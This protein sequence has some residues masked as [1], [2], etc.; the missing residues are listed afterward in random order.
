M[1]R[2]QAVQTRR[3]L[4]NSAHARRSA[5][6]RLLSGVGLLLIGFAMIA[7]L[8]FPLLAPAPE[9][10]P[11]ELVLDIDSNEAVLQEVYIELDEQR[12]TQQLFGWHERQPN[13]RVFAVTRPDQGV[14][15]QDQPRMAL[16]VGHPWATQDSVGDLTAGAPLCLTVA[17]TVVA[18]G[19]EWNVR[20]ASAPITRRY[21]ADGTWS[22][23][24]T[25]TVGLSPALRALAHDD[26]FGLEPTLELSPFPH[27]WL[28]DTQGF[29]TFVGCEGCETKAVF[30]D[31]E[32]VESD[33]AFGQV[34]LTERLGVEIVSPWQPFASVS[35]GS[36]GGVLLLAFGSAAVVGALGFLWR[37]RHD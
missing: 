21:L 20:L 27:D 37:T 29:I 32:L 34:R 8:V 25:V 26:A 35:P 33:L 19:W 28:G 12:D 1:S 24:W 9:P 18:T 3:S 2:R 14:N 5:I 13:L 31:A 15:C 4:R 16:E 7:L 23:S 10:R 11:I 6:R 22:E 36:V 17:D 30:G